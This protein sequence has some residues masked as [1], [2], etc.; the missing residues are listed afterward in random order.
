[1]S[2]FSNL[3]TEGL[4]KSEDRL[5]GGGFLRE[6]DIYTG[7]IK[8]AYAGKSDGGAQNVTIIFV[9]GGKEYRE[10]I[11]ITNK[12]GE[13]F[14]LNK[15]D[16]SKK[17]PLPGFTL[18]NDICLCTTEK[19]LSKQETEKKMVNIYDYDLKKEVA[20]SVDC[21]VDVQGQTVSLGIIKVLENKGVK[22]GD[23]SYAPGPETRELNAIEKVFHT[24]SHFTMVEVDA[25]AEEATF[26]DSWV[27]KNKGVTRDKRKIK[28]GQAGKPGSAP[29][30]GDAGNAPKKSLFAKG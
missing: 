26:W 11:Y 4:E 15:E 6:T 9:E 18:I 19:P 3:G 14:F 5:G 13:N 2:L 20:T 7:T 27:E 25:G 1:M 16:N 21:L 24:E 10:T 17:V 30:A 22:Q 29:K 28:D 12:K 8:V 23:G